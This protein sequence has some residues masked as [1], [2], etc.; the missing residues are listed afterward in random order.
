MGTT[1]LER[2]LGLR[3]LLYCIQGILIEAMFK[4]L[5]NHKLGLELSTKMLLS[6]GPKQRF[7]SSIRIRAHAQILSHINI[8]LAPP[9][10][11]DFRTLF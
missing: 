2:A 6:I 8:F 11:L 4:K 1:S 7:A 3:H 10:V 5:L 9:Q